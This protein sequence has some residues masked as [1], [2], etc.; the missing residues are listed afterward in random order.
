MNNDSEKIARLRKYEARERRHRITSVLFSGLVLV[1]IWVSYREEYD[2]P[3]FAG[4]DG[5]GRLRFLFVSL[6]L[7]ATFLTSLVLAFRLNRVE[8]MLD[9]TEPDL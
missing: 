1:L 3:R 2:R 5:I 8:K 9:R 6:G 7:T 4:Q